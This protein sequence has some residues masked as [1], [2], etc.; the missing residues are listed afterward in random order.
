MPL[1]LGGSYVFSPTTVPTHKTPSRH[2]RMRRVELRDIFDG[3]FLGWRNP[4]IVLRFSGPRMRA[5]EVAA[6]ARD[7]RSDGAGSNAGRREA[8]AH[9]RRN[10]ARSAL[11]L[12]PTRLHSEP[13]MTV[14]PPAT[15]TDHFH[16]PRPRCFSTMSNAAKQSSPV[17]EVMP[18][19]DLGNH[20]GGRPTDAAR[21]RP[22][23][24]IVRAPSRSWRSSAGGDGGR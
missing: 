1:E 20:R 4:S 18:L 9:S 12:A 14:S 10:S 16:L 19:T 23:F 5:W 22:G 11:Y 7:E 3:D 17:R 8:L 6:A 2:H 13:H 21:A 24:C 15:Q